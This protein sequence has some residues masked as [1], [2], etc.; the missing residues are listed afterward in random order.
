MK[1]IVVI[2]LFTLL[3]GIAAAREKSY[4]VSSPDGTI[5]ITLS[6]G[7]RFAYEVHVD[8][9]PVVAPT[10]I[11]MT[12]DDGSVWGGPAQPSRIRKGT[13]DTSFATPFYIKE[14]AAARVP[15]YL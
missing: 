13:A 2:A 8:G 15:R 11:A 14:R 10:P 1:K 12:L 4:T 3:A 5:G 7:E 6:L 9:R